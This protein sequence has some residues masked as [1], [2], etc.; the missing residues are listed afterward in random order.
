MPS[1]QDLE[2]ELEGNDIEIE[3]PKNVGTYGIKCNRVTEKI[4]VDKIISI[5][6]EEAERIYRARCVDKNL[7]FD[8]V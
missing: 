5:T 8:K 1:F 2:V 4:I 6:K 3:S 7:N